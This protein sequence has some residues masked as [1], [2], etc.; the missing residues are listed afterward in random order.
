MNISLY[1][2]ASA[3]N[4]NA[5]WQEVIAEN[6]A[7]SSTPGF[8][9][10][11]LTVEAVRAGLLPAQTQASNRL[12]PPHFTL[13]NA[14]LST[15]FTPGELR[16]TG[17]ITDLA[18]EGPGFF[19]VQLANGASAYTRDGEFRLNAQGQ[20]TTKQGY[21]VLGD[22]GFIQIDPNN[23]AP[24]VVSPSGEVSQGTDQLG[25][26]RAVNFDQPNLLQPI[27]GAL[28][29]A[30]DPN[31]TREVAETSTL[32]QGWLE[33]ANTT[34]SEE[35]ASLLTAMRPFEA[36][37]RVIQIQDERMAKAIEELGNP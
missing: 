15:N 5:R 27:S 12:V 35:M 21:P 36:N 23:P 7:S 30:Q 29:L 8:R 32:R 9:K 26:I 11:E 33:G 37:Q 22:S 34:V 31:L 1:Q 19:E 25:R 18:I 20:L 2:A 16:Y 28:F 13:P 3:L 14:S 10:Q 4:A 24:I 17:S 6:L